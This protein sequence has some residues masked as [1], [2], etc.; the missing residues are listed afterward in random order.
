[1]AGLAFAAWLALITTDGATWVVGGVVV[2][3]VVTGFHRAGIVR[4][5]GVR[6]E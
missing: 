1:V 4:L 2:L 6:T 5:E 3:A